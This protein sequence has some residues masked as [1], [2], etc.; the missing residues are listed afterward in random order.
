MT[1]RSRQ[2]MRETSVYA[3]LI[4]GMPTEAGVLGQVDV[5]HSNRDVQFAEKGNHMASKQKSRFS[6][7]AASAR[8]GQSDQLITDGVLDLDE[9]TEVIPFS[10]AITAYGADYT[11]DGLVK[12]LRDDAI[13]VPVFGSEEAHGKNMRDSFQRQYVWKKQQ[14][15]RFVESLLLGL[16][17]PGIFLVK[18]DDGRLLVLDG[19]QRLVTLKRFYAKD[20]EGAAFTLDS[21]QARYAN[22]TYDDLDPSDRRRLDDSIIHATIV[23]QDE[24]S[25]D[26]SSIYLVFERLNSGGT[27]D[28]TRVGR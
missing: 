12:R 20:W 24:P 8:A 9:A 26:R 28:S 13:I 11:V 17:V 25:E 2:V 7:A 27:A 22:K 19:H 18:E 15:D 23:R 10:Y 5:V 21:V 14:A 3:L 6:Q 4:V 16:P 1:S